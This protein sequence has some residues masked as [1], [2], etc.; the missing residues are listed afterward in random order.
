VAVPGT[1][2]ALSLLYDQSLR[3]EIAGWLHDQ[4]GR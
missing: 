3:D 1:A 2:H 4:L